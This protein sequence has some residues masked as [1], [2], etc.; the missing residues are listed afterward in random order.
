MPG[1][2]GVPDEPHAANVSFYET[3]GSG[4]GVS[5]EPFVSASGLNVIN[6]NAV[7]NAQVASNLCFQILLDDC[8][9]VKW[10]TVL[11]DRKLFIE[12]P[13]GILPEGSKESFVTLLEYAEESL[14]CSHVVVCFK[15]ARA[16]RACLMRTFMFLGFGVVSP[17][18]GLV[19]ARGDLLF[20][21][22]NIDDD[23]P[24]DG[25]GDV[26]E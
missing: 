2:S 16:D 25:E 8:M 1:L 17:T 19:P 4:V 26:D 20:M 13:S 11:L 24:E 10:E 18:S 5:K 22:Y 9:Q 21:A 14:K 6:T 12:I 15:K 23:D 7:A 3:E